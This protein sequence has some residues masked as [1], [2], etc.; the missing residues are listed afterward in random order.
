M[1]FLSMAECA[2]AGFIRQDVTAGIFGAFNN[3]KFEDK[4]IRKEVMSV[5]EAIETRLTW[6]T[7][8][9]TDFE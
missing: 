6:S 8:S 9:K 4:K 7:F 5:L 1:N 3:G 2:G